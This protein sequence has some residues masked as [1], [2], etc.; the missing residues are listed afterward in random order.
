V[1]ALISEGGIEIMTLGEFSQAVI[2]HRWTGVTIF[3]ICALGGLAL[4]LASRPLYQATALFQVQQL[5]DLGS[6]PRAWDVLHGVTPRLNSDVLEKWLGQEAVLQRIIDLAGDRGQVAVA[7]L[8]RRV[9]VIPAGDGGIY[10][11]TVW[12]PSPDRAQRLAD[13]MAVVLG[14]LGISIVQQDRQAL[15]DRVRSAM[16]EAR[17]LFEAKADAASP[18]PNPGQADTGLAPRQS[19]RVRHDAALALYTHLETQLLALEVAQRTGAAQVRILQKAG[20]PVAPVTPG[21]QLYALFGI[22]SGAVLGLAGIF[23]REAGRGAGV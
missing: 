5:A 10:E 19:A 9:S 4:G 1:V 16:A 12:D 18:G 3:A 23:L 17:I 14:N 15:I 2:R 11:S 7:Q 8:R 21:W 20:R 22:V 13:A 6:D